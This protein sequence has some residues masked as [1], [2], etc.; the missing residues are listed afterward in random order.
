V[1][2]GILTGAM[3]FLDT[4]A[5]HR[6]SPPWLTHVPAVVCVLLGLCISP[7]RAQPA[8][9]YADIAAIFRDSCVLCHQ[10]EAAPLGLRLD[11]YAAV[12]K[13]SKNRRVVR[14]GEPDR[15][16]LVKRLRGESVP[17]MPMTGPPWLSDEAV[18]RIEKWIAAGAPEGEPIAAPAPQRKEGDPVTYRDVAPLIAGRCLKCHTDHG[19]QEPPPEGYRLDG[20]ARILSTTDRARVVPG[21]PDASELIRRVRGQSQ[22]R[23]PYD[24]PPYLSDAEVAL[25]EQWVAQG[26]RD[27]AGKPAPVPTGARVRLRG[28]LDAKGRLDGLPL[29]AGG[30]RRARP[31]QLVEVRGV[32]QADGTVRPERVRP[33]E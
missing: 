28:T 27:A 9:T 10:G 31:G 30:E 19:P 15:S 33:K 2:C 25:L 29:G 11:S 16:E 26:A 7:V 14:P 23:M 18:A 32:L 5:R 3:T 21:H 13:G 8:P 20:Y 12:M 1:R 6:A 4:C 17:R 24:G 22:P